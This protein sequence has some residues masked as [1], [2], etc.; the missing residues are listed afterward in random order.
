MLLS[1]TGS[2]TQQ[3]NVVLQDNANTMLDFHEKGTVTTETLKIQ[4]C[5]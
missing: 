1:N 4:V 2:P 3:S 5:L